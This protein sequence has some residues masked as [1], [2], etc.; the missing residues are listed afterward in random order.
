MIPVSVPYIGYSVI[1]ALTGLPIGYSVIVALTDLPIGYRLYLLCDFVADTIHLV[2]VQQ[3]RGAR[4]GIKFRE[5]LHDICKMAVPG[6]T[7]NYTIH[8]HTHTTIA[9]PTIS[10]LISEPKSPVSMEITAANQDQSSYMQHLTKDKLQENVL[11]VRIYP[12][13]LYYF[14]LIIIIYCI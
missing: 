5:C 11:L 2:E 8:S 3:L 6:Q 7:L 10:Q 12:N 1:V 13:I 14:N 9:L 4:S